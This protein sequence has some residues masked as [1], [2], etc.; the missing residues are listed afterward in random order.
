MEIVALPCYLLE[1]WHLFSINIKILFL[2][3]V[4]FLI[5]LYL[6]CVSVISIQVSSLLTQWIFF[7]NNTFFSIDYLFWKHL[8]DNW[9][10]KFGNSLRWFSRIGANGG[11]FD[12]R[13]IRRGGGGA[14]MKRRWTGCVVYRLGRGW[15]EMDVVRTSGTMLFWRCN[16]RQ[17]GPWAD[18]WP[19]IREQMTVAVQTWTRPFCERTSLP[20]ARNFSYPRSSTP[21]PLSRSRKIDRR[22]R[23]CPIPKTDPTPPI[24]HRVH[25]WIIIIHSVKRGGGLSSK[26]ESAAVYIAIEVFADRV[27]EFIRGHDTYRDETTDECGR[28]KVQRRL[29]RRSFSFFSFFFSPPRRARKSSEA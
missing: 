17:A 2:S 27:E 22:A 6:L 24:I 19:W 23:S 13:A 15:R 8:L 14:W 9:L 29:G 25:P 28:T 26:R 7:P 5:Q 20:A 11:E 18:K 21:A 3:I 10:D 4:F 16:K 1:L 12:K